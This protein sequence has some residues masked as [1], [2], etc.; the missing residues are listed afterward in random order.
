M[1]AAKKSAP[2]KKGFT[3]PKSDGPKV[4]VRTPNVPGYTSQVD[5][6]KY[7]AMKK[8]MLK[9]M[10]K[11][12]PGI[13]QNEMFALLDKAAPK[14]VFPKTT[15]MW[16]GMCLKLDLEARGELVRDTSAK[17]LRWRRA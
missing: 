3:V 16:W 4:S 12:D 7:A 14:D 10:P 8:V 6:A 9:I 5:A 1:P 2:K 11:K 17:P 15:Y 13:T